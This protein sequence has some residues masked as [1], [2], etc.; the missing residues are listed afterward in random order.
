M[1]AKIAQLKKRKVF[2]FRFFQ[3][4]IFNYYGCAKEFLGPPATNVAFI[5]VF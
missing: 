2:T 4:I 1:H 3:N 5:R